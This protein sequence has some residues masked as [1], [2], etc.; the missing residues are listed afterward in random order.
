MVNRTSIT[1]RDFL[2][3]ASAA[4]GMAALA[5]ST[6]GAEVSPGLAAPGGWAAV[7]WCQFTGC[8]REPASLRAKL[9]WLHTALD[10]P[11][12]ATVTLAGEPGLGDSRAPFVLTLDYASGA[13]VVLTH[14]GP[15]GVRVRASE[16][17][18]EQ[19]APDSVT[20]RRLDVATWETLR[21]VMAALAHGGTA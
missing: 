4:L 19:T 14:A 13:T 17:E 3:T 8:A 1:R 21:R 15:P 6:A 7:R 18:V 20:G 2:A 9:V 16:G 12:P 10:A 11:P 5:P